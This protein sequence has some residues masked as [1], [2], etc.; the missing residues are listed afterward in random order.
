MGADA[1]GVVMSKAKI[2]GSALGGAMMLAVGIVGTFEG[3]KQ[4]AYIDPVGIPTICTGHTGPEV[5][6][7]DTVTKEV[8]DDLLAQDLSG[9]FSALDRNVPNAA[10][11]PAYT[12]AAMA[13]FIYNLGESAFKSSPM[14]AMLAA[15][16]IE[17]ACDA[18]LPYNTATK[19]DKRG[20]PVIDPKTGKKVKVFLK[21]LARRREAER[22]LCRG[23][24][25]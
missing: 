11:L 23:E 8:C 14:P 22:H 10:V 25:W 5:H 15:G 24:A 7:G 6:A 19:R 13:S 20:N 9:A 17:A 21:G 1:T 16:R 3:T 4:T 2:I 18:L 12:R